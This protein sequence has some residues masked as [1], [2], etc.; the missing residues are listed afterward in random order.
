MAI[1]LPLTLDFSAWYA[2]RVAM[3][4]AIIAA[5]ELYAWRTAT[6]HA[7]WMYGASDSVMALRD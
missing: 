3:T 7:Q 1:R 2:G 5:I 6:A 4:M